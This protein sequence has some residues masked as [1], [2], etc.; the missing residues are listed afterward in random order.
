MKLALTWFGTLSQG[1]K[2]YLSAAADHGFS[3]VA[4]LSQD[5]L[6]GQEWDHFDPKDRGR[7][8]S[9]SWASFASDRP[10][11]EPESLS[12]T[13]AEA[14]QRSI[15]QWQRVRVGLL[16][17]GS[18]TLIIDAGLLE[19]P[20]AKERGDRLLKTLWE[21]GKPGEADESL[22][23]LQR[24]SDQDSGIQ[25][26]A[27]ARFL[28]AIHQSA[29]SLQIALIAN[30]S[31]AGLLRPSHFSLLQK[32]AGLDWL[33]YWH[34]SGLSQARAAFSLEEPGDWL[35]VASSSLLG[36]TLHDWADGQDL[37]LPGEGIV[38]FQ[39]ISEYLP[40]TATRVLAAAPVYPMESLPL[41]REA[42]LAFGI[43]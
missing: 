14:W 7:I 27:L 1:L 42:L 28:H 34:D 35:D 30:E 37:L 11:E 26:E 31:P 9:V 18:K 17:L 38:D 13:N 23:P 3:G 19:T 24:L 25:L 29:P 22:E 20:G 40:R 33:G 4:A 2:S 15:R 12:S 8:C 16:A 41:A 32:D 5:D 36:C 21:S 43:H 10:P 6:K 39:L